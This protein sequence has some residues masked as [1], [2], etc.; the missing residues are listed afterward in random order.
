MKKHGWK[1]GD[2]LGT[3]RQG[4]TRCISVKKRQENLGIGADMDTSATLFKGMMC[5]YNDVLSK[6][7]KSLSKKREP[8]RNIPSI[9]VSTH[10]FRFL[11]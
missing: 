4:M 3:K 9:F 8:F 1:R 11:R 2:G 7:K 6:L 10:F 5:M